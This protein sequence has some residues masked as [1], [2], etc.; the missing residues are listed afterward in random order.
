M[1]EYYATGGDDPLDL[2][3]GDMNLDGTPDVVVA[4]N[5]ASGCQ[6]DDCGN[7]SIMRNAAVPTGVLAPR[8]ACEMAGRTSVRLRWWK[9]GDGDLRIYRTETGGAWAE[10]VSIGGASGQEGT[11]EDRDVIGGRRYGYRLRSSMIGRTEWTEPIW[12]DVPPEADL[13]IRT[14][15]IRSGELRVVLDLAGGDAAMLEVWDVNG[16]RLAARRIVGGGHQELDLKQ[17]VAGIYFLRLQQGERSVSAKAV[18]CR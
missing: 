2:A 6:T 1:P 4:N 17:P 12:V 16:R 13:A 14:L 7:V 3:I 15:G 18:V 9:S 11:F 5:Y 10:I 8:L